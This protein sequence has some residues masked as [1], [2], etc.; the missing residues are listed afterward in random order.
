M[1][2]TDTI[3]ANRNAEPVIVNR[4]NFIAAYRRLSCPQPAIRKY[5]GTRTNS[6]KMKN[7][8][9]SRARNTPI[10]ADSSSSIQ[11][12]NCFGLATLAD[13]RIAIGNSSALSAT[14]NKLMPSTPSVHRTP[15]WP[16]QEWS[17]RSWYPDLSGLASNWVRRNSAIPKVAML[18]TYPTTRASSGRRTGMS[19]VTSAPAAGRNTRKVNSG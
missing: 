19:I 11:T 17:S 18:V 5:I 2:A 7:T 15:S 1:N 8:I 12:M 3:P 14:M 13:A 10:I 16:I 9:A 4:K 6:K